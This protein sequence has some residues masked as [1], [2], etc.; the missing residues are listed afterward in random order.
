MAFRVTSEIVFGTPRVHF[1]TIV[2][3]SL[4]GVGGGGGGGVHGR[5]SWLPDYFR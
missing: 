1:G 2:E 4:G 5:S 3:G